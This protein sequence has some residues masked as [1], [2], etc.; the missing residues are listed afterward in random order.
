MD[1][2]EKKPFQPFTWSNAIQQ[3]V[4]DWPYIFG[5]SSNAIEVQRLK[6][7]GSNEADAIAER[8]QVLDSPNYVARFQNGVLISASQSTMYAIVKKT[9]KF[10]CYN[11]GAPDDHYSVNCQSIDQ[12][13]TRC[14]QCRAV[15]KSA[16]GHKIWCKNTRKIQVL[17]RVNIKCQV[18]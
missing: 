8:V 15:V 10:F 5:I 14:P 11:C 3:L 1:S 4:L 9:I 13:Y 18:V 7:I 2:P 12:Q 17:F 16:T 6:K